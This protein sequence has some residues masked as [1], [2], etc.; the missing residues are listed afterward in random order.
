MLDIPNMGRLV[1]DIKTGRA[2][3]ADTAL[4]LA[5]YANAL[6]LW[7]GTGLCPMPGRDALGRKSDERAVRTDLG[8]IIHLRSEA[9]AVI[10]VNLREG[11]RAFTSLCALRRWKE[12]EGSVLGEPLPLSGDG[13]RREWLKGR[14][15]T[16][17]TIDGALEEL[18]RCWPLGVP[19]F[20]NGSDH[21][22]AQLEQ[23]E[24]AVG[25]AEKN[26][27]APFPTERPKETVT[28][29]VESWLRSNPSN[30]QRSSCNGHW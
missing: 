17:E 25:A 4:Q 16:L 29:D 15:A 1:V 21:T 10:P 13:K 24:R 20:K 7:D 18:A 19:T 2:V 28:A 30:S 23:I 8:L 5:A 26:F 11:W 3:Y 27:D 6:Y 22:A 9:G 14:I 12:R